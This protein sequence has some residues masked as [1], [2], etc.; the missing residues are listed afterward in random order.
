MQGDRFLFTEN[1]A[2]YI[3]HDTQERV[4]TYQTPFKICFHDYQ[5]RNPVTYL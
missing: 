5:H 4:L 3:K 2:W 1:V